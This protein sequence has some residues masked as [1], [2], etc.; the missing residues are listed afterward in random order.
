MKYRV[1]SGW[2][3]VIGPPAAICSMNSGMTLPD[4]PMTLPKRTICAFMLDSAATSRS[5]ISAARLLAPITLVGLMALSVEMKTNRSTPRPMQSS[6]TM[7]VAS[8][9][10]RRYS[11]GFS[12]PSG[13][14]LCAAEWRTIC[15]FSPASSASTA[16]VSRMSTMFELIRQVD[17][18]A[19]L[20]RRSRTSYSANSERSASAMLSG[21]NCAT[22]EASSEPIVPPAPVI[23]TRFPLN[24]SR[25][26][27]P[28]R[29]MRLRRSRSSTLT[30]RSCET[31][32][33]PLTR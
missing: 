23:R 25:T 31:C 11:A 15:G 14:C 32:T 8:A 24:S 9:L 20:A 3:T 22:C 26:G 4:E 5:R 33:L 16:S 19:S 6:A 27:S 17:A 7:R 18:A 21:S 13:T 30:G 2:V 1:T 10:L 28:G 29:S 12:S